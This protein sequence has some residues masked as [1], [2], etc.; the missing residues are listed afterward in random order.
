MYGY[1]LLHTVPTN[2]TITVTDHIQTVT[3]PFTVS[4]CYIQKYTVIIT[5][6]S[7]LSDALNQTGRGWL[8]LPA[9]FFLFVHFNILLFTPR[10]CR[11]DITPKF[12]FVRVISTS[13][14]ML[15]QI[16]FCVC[17]KL[18]AKCAL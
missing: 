6:S 4:Y 10:P 3:L 2:N 14:N 9:M 15:L 8:D 1:T 18:C 7:I 5:R 13:D 12:W 16:I 11:A 17:C